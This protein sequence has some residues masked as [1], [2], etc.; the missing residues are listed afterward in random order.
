MYELDVMV[1][2]LFI[3]LEDR[4]CVPITYVN[5]YIANVISSLNKSGH[6]IQFNIIRDAYDDLIW[7]CPYFSYKYRFDGAPLIF[8]DGSITID[9]LSILY[10]NS[11]ADE[12]KFAFGFLPDLEHDHDVQDLDN[13]IDCK[14]LV[15][16]AS[17]IDRST[18]CVD[19]S[20]CVKVK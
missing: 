17:N 4:R 12:H 15:S 8:F 2:N 1:A 10:K 16:V 13:Y 5:S 20:C 6:S 11:V 9:E 7:K 14:Q 3:L 19:N 18:N